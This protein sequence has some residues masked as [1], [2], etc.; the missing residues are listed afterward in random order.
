MFVQSR[1]IT[2][3]ISVTENLPCHCLVYLSRGETR[4][5]SGNGVEMF[6]IV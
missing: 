4:A 6:G 2:S 3:K 1:D 5:R